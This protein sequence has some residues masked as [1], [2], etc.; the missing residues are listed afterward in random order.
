MIQDVE[1]VFVYL[2]R[3]IEKLAEG[4]TYSQV[5]VFTDRLDYL[6]SM[7]NYQAYAVAVE[8]LAGIQAPER[9]KSCALSWP[10]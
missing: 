3:G 8:K 5:M 1:P 9:V 2:H 10:N 6:A 7:P 4:L